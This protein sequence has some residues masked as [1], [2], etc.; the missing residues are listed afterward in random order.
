M[1]ELAVTL[2]VGATVGLVAWK[3]LPS[4]RGVGEGEP[5]AQ[6][7]ALAQASL[8]GFVLRSHRLPCPDA[9]GAGQE[10]CTGAGGAPIG[11]GRL[12]WR[13]LGL[14]QSFAALRYGVHRATAPEDNDL[15]QARAR[16]T[17]FLP[18]AYLPA[19]VA[20]RVNGLDL[21]VALRR[22]AR[23][24]GG[25]GALSVG[26]VAAAYALAHPGDDGQFQGDNVA[27]FAVPGQPK[28][29]DYDDVVA[30]AGLNELSGRLA[31]PARLGEANA[32]ARAAFAAYDLDRDAQQFLDFRSMARD[33]RVTSTQFAIAKEAMAGVDLLI[34]GASFTTALAVAANS[35][36]LG[37]KVVG[38]AALPVAASAVAFVVATAGL[39]S[40]VV[41]ETKAKA[42]LEG[43]L[44]L[45]QEYGT[46]LTRAVDAAIVV[47]TKGLNP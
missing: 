43:A 31:C 8:E 1:V 36:G 18:A 2:A 21:C 44:A 23:A 25:A 38:L 26:G 27:G 12:P 37:A 46:A 3:L 33:V 39:A 30:S 11:V 45:K 32:A 9:E 13:A 17:P 5:V 4:S 40:A 10:T 7:V 6:Q 16:Q 41:S 15:A 29:A 20:T 19:E 42:Q 28:T 47:D 24:T 14:P 35:V 34:A 22:A